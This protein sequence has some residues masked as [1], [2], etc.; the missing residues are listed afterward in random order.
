MIAIAFCSFEIFASCALR[1]DSK[2]PG[3]PWPDSR[4]YR[5]PDIFQFPPRKG[6]RGD[7]DS[8]VLDK[9]LK[10]PSIPLYKRGKKK[11]SS[12]DFLEHF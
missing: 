7:F 11:L 1:P 6:G 8:P 4:L 12:T 2:Y 5:K 9:P 10:S 3:H